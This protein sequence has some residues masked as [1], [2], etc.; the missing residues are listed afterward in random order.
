MTHA[1]V[2]ALT[3]II[4]NRPRRNPPTVA[5]RTNALIPTAAPICRMNCW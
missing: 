1:N 5:A 2:P 4:N 3:A